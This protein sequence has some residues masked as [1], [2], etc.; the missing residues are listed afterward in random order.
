MKLKNILAIVVNAC[1]LFA[2]VEKAATAPESLIG[3]T[4]KAYKPSSGRKLIKGIPYIKQKGAYCAPASAAM[5]LKYYGADVT[6]DKLAHLASAKTLA[7]KGTPLHKLCESIR[8]LGYKSSLMYLNDPSIRDSLPKSQKHFLEHTVN[9]IIERIDQDKPVLFTIAKKGWPTTHLIVI[10]GYDQNKKALY[11]MDPASRQNK[12]H[13]LSYEKFSIYGN[14]LSDNSYYQVAVFVEPNSDA[15]YPTSRNK[16]DFGKAKNTNG[17][18][19]Y[20]K[21]AM[22]EL[23][24]K[25]ISEQVPLFQILPASGYINNQT[26]RFDFENIDLLR[27]DLNTSK[28]KSQ[29]FAKK[30]SLPAI[31]SSLLNKKIVVV[32]Y[33]NSDEENTSSA[34]QTTLQ[35]ESNFTFLILTGYNKDSQKF[36]VLRPNKELNDYTEEGLTYMGLTNRLNSKIISTTAQGRKKKIYSQ[37]VIIFSVDNQN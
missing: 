29:T 15:R 1:L 9:T 3:A 32:I 24:S 26:T 21:D 25:S 20:I 27:N 30:H 28:T 8:K 35:Q 10:V 33:T 36:N 18:I 7:K 6:Q 4:E 23:Q 14:L 34:K 22:L 11:Y 31:E 2:F 17:N 12:I 13:R 5:L 19:A 37:R 16:K